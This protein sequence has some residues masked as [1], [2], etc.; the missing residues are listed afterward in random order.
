MSLLGR[1]VDDIT[2][3]ILAEESSTNSC[4]LGP[5]YRADAPLYENGE[6]IIQKYLGGE[7]TWYHGRILDVDSGKPVAGKTKMSLAI[8]SGPAIP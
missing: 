2:H 3:K 8:I 1:L 4:I 7:I 6:S 5:F